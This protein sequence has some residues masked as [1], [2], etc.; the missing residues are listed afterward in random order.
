MTGESNSRGVKALRK[1]QEAKRH[2]SAPIHDVSHRVMNRLRAD[3]ARAEGHE[4]LS[5]PDSLL[6]AVGEAAH[7]DASRD[8][9]LTVAESNLVDTLQRPNSVSVGASEQRMEAAERLGVFRPAVD[10]SVS[11]RAR[12]SLEK[13]LCHQMAATHHA[14]MALLASAVNSGLPPV[15]MARLTNASARMMDVYQAA[16]LT[17]QK[18]RT[19]GKQTVVVQH[20]RV[21]DGGQAI[22]AGKVKAGNRGGRP[23]RG[24]RSVRKTS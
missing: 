14:A 9:P 20:V 8:Q 12:N 6:Q 13:M 19:G 22:I 10:A 15:E 11:A 2:E 17:L 21:S 16:M 1:F 4:L 5:A 23:G 3:E 24:A 7:F 18:C